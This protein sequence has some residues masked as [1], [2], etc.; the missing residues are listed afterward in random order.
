MRLPTLLVLPDELLDVIFSF[1]NTRDLFWISRVSGRLRRAA[2]FPFLNRHGISQAQVQSGLLIFREEPPE[3]YNTDYLLLLVLVSNIRPILKLETPLILSGIV[4]LKRLAAVLSSLPQ[5]PHIL[6][7]VLYSGIPPGLTS[8]ILEASKTP[9]PTVVF[10]QPDTVYISRPR[11]VRPGPCNPWIAFAVVPIFLVLYLVLGP[12]YPIVFTV[13]LAIWV[14]NCLFRPRWPQDERIT[15]DLGAIHGNWIRIQALSSPSVD[16][17]TMVTFGG[18]SD[19]DSTSMTIPP[20]ARAHRCIPLSHCCNVTV[21]AVLDCLHR[22]PRLSYLILDE[23][24][25]SLPSLFFQS[26]QH[27]PTSNNLTSLSVS[28]AYIPHILHAAKNVQ[29]ISITS[30]ETMTKET[31]DAI[32]L[33]PGTHRISLALY[34][35]KFPQAADCLWQPALIFMPLPRVAALLISTGKEPRSTLD[36]PSFARWLAACFPQ[37]VGLNFRGLVDEECIV[38]RITFDL[39]WLESRKLQRSLLKSSRTEI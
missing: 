20:H 29:N 37:L 27:T 33:L 22:H 21:S 38:L 24:S 28:A 8:L 2:V 26:S 9:I 17:L 30:A 16:G 32:A 11:N 31:M 7:H 12:V 25:I 23:K 34:F 35:T 39:R 6:I 18:D 36:I 13:R 19:I 15:H 14:Y 1:L 10:F 5:I 3:P 4:A